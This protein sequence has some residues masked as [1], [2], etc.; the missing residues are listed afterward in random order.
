[1]SVA[2]AP[3]VAAPP[4]ARIVGPPRPPRWWERLEHLAQPPERLW[5]RGRAAPRHPCVAIV[6]SRRA[7][8]HALRA[9]RRIGM[10]LA[11]RGIQVVS[12]LALGVD[13]QAHRGALDG[14]GTTVAVLAC[15]VEQCYPAQHRG[16]HADVLRHGCVL[17]EERPGTAPLPYL[18][19]K[20]NRLIAA[21]AVAVVVV[22]A[23]DRSGAL[24]TARHAVELGR[25]VLACPAN[26]LNDGALGSNRLLRD[27]AAPYLG[28]DSLL[29]AV[30]SLAEAAQ[31]AREAQQE[32][33]TR[34]KSGAA[35]GTTGS[36][37][38]PDE[39]S[40]DARLLTLVGGG[41]VH[42]HDLL[43]WLGVD[44]RTLSIRLGRLEAE[45]I[46]SILPGGLVSAAARTE[47][48]W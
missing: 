14:G 24:S 45:G 38:V 34:S 39:E 12:G 27:G 19:P 9:A 16:L 3:A 33:R 20:R 31:R 47:R 48:V 25:E 7:S 11:A 46:V 43:H 8:D 4:D 2:E 17:T 44:A 30:P 37:A 6:G 41:A 13:A 35:A 21:L 5:L 1:M 23:G 29:D 32:R 36:R 22:E 10:D 42:P 28:V 40:L 15:G 26:Y 18:F